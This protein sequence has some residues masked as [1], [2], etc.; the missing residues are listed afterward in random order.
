MRKDDSPRFH[1][2]QFII[3]STVPSASG[4]L[5]F[6]ISPPFS[7]F[8]SYRRRLKFCQ[9]KKKSFSKPSISAM[10]HRQYETL[11]PVKSNHFLVDH[12]NHHSRLICHHRHHRFAPVSMLAWV[13]LIETMFFLVYL[14]LAYPLPPAASTCWV[15]SIHL[16]Y[17][18]KPSQSIFA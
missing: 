18:P 6:S 12:L 15:I 10:Q 9:K 3:V 13:L 7:I 2:Y 14:V 16:H 17:M 11:G 1:R 5:F 4:L 8:S